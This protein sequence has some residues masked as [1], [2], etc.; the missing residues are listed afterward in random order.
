MLAAR[1]ADGH[2]R[3]LR[4][5]ARRGRRLGRDLVERGRFRAF[6]FELGRHDHV[7]ARRGVAPPR[8]RRRELRLRILPQRD[9]EGREPEQDQP[10]ED[11]NKGALL[12]HAATCIARSS[13]WDACAP[14]AI[15]RAAGGF[16]AD[17]SGAPFRYDGV[18]LQNTGGILACHPAIVDRVL[19]IVT[20]VGRRAHVL[21]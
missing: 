13:A 17:L 12:A 20:E 10:H 6:F 2:L 1:S 15:L 9:V 14:E 11:P 7:L 4:V 19:P 18:E 8:R 21:Q 16:F 3:S 5:L